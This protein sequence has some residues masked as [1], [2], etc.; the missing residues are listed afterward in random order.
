MENET[1][2]DIAVKEF[3][4]DTDKNFAPKANKLGA[5]Q[6]LVK[7]YNAGV[8]NKD[9]PTEPTISDMSGSGF[10]NPTTDNSYDNAVLDYYN[11]TQNVD[12]NKIKRDVLKQ[13]Q[14]QIDATKR[15]YS[16]LLGEVKQQSTGRLG[17]DTA[18]QS[19]RGLLGSD[20]GSAQTEKT[21]NL[22]Y[23]NEE[24]VRA[25]ESAALAAIKSQALGLAQQEIAANKAAKLQ[26][27]QAWLESLR[28]KP[29]RKN[30]ALANLANAFL[31]QNKNPLEMSQTEL[32]KIADESNGFFT[33]QDIINSYLNTKQAQEAAQKEQDL[34]FRGKEADISKT[35]KETEMIDRK[36]EEDKRQFGMSYALQ[37]RNVALNERKAALDSATLGTEGDVEGKVSLITSALQNA[38]DLSEASGASGASKMIGNFLVGDTK[39]NQLNT[40]VDTLKTNILALA[41]DPNIKK[42]FGPQMSNADV[43]LMQSVGTTLD[44]SSQTPEQMNQELKRLEEVF[45]RLGVYGGESSQPETQVVNGITYQKA[46]DGLY[47]PAN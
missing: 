3:T 32:Q 27:S 25:A 21:R 43:R 20:F 23:T 13:F 19:R 15:S 8:F 28:T 7:L 24:K 34:E 33:V 18:M 44:P 45:T 31:T 38:K 39:Y 12:E 4:A 37:A 41:T 17:E 9:T 10:Q 5:D 42:F 46:A 2:T 40:Y 36:F 47:Y 29:K 26:G 6:D 1:T 30:E 11:Q 16:Q 14:G 35:L 22:N